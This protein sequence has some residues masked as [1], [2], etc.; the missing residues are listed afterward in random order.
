MV[1]RK[2]REYG[3]ASEWGWVDVV[4]LPYSDDLPF[5]YYLT[6]EGSTCVFGECPSPVIDE[7]VDIYDNE[8][9][10]IDPEFKAYNGLKYGKNISRFRKAILV[11]R[12]L[13]IEVGR[14]VNDLP[15]DFEMP[16]FDGW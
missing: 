16:E 15:E 5:A 1:K 10:G 11:L 2:D 6:W 9:Y 13:H 12:E 7:L 8:Y 4:P 14:R 3:L